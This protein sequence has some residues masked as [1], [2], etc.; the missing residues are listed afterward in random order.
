MI[1]ALIK[2]ITIAKKKRNRPTALNSAIL[3]PAIIPISSKNK[4][5]TPLNGSMKNGLTAVIPFSPTAKPISKL[6]NSKTTLALKRDSLNKST[7]F[8]FS[9][10]ILS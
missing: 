5:N 6:P 4:V 9:E 10:A 1:D 7:V 8:D 2:G 3:F